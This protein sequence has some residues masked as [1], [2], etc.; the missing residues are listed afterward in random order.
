MSVNQ[1]DATSADD[2]ST[3][4]S[5]YNLTI[6]SS[7]PSSPMVSTQSRASDDFIFLHPVPPR[8]QSQHHP[9]LAISMSSVGLSLNPSMVDSSVFS[10]GNT[11]VSEANHINNSNETTS[12]LDALSHSTI[13]SSISSCSLSSMPHHTHISFANIGRSLMQLSARADDDVS[14]SSCGTSCD[15]S[16]ASA[17][18]GCDGT[19]V[20]ANKWWSNFQTE[21]DWESFR[22]MANEYISMLVSSEMREVEKGKGCDV[23]SSSIVLKRAPTQGRN[24]YYIA[25]QWL[26]GLY[27][28]LSGGSSAL[29]KRPDIDIKMQYLTSLIKEATSIQ[30]RLEEL[31]TILPPLP[32]VQALDG[33]PDETRQLLTQHYSLFESLRADTMHKR[34][35]LQADYSH[36]QEKIL[37]TIIESEE[38]LF[39]TK[40][41]GNGEEI[42]VD[43]LIGAN[44]DDG[45]VKVVGRDSSC[46]DDIG[47]TLATTQSKCPMTFHVFV[48]AVAAGAGFFLSLQS[49]RK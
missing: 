3:S 29:T 36:C 15:V 12:E 21:E 33:I 39:W 43:A 4:S 40:T 14:T 25:R 5:N 13:T 16:V 7:V 32:D 27:D 1:D 8:Q 20:D 24:V 19:E 45:F 6:L 22:R 28:V 2:R 9:S 11:I 34:E 26:E 49:N 48:A 38:E 42:K 37:A 30:Q 44:N 35:V 23:K 31:P 47:D 18:I 46:W 10:L 17:R 41:K